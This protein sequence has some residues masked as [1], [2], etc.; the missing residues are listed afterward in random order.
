MKYHIVQFSVKYA[1]G[2][3]EY[4]KLSNALRLDYCLKSFAQS[5]DLYQFIDE[6]GLSYVYRK[7]ALYLNGG[8]DPVDIVDL[9]E[10]INEYNYPDNKTF[11]TAQRILTKKV[12]PLPEAPK[13]VAEPYLPHVAPPLVKSTVQLPTEA[14]KDLKYITSMEAYMLVLDQKLKVLLMTLQMYDKM[15]PKM[16]DVCIPE[17]EMSIK[18]YYMFY[19]RLTSFISAKSLPTE[20][21]NTF[22]NI[23]SAIKS[24]EATVNF[25]LK[26]KDIYSNKLAEMKTR[27]HWQS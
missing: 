27:K 13:K 16:L 2:I 11:L 17:W 12:N 14:I 8:L 26:D 22:S 5:D 19:Q 10:D 25:F 7:K 9:K 4:Y 6:D 3:T 23:H 24:F 15:Q 21:I 18:K 1:N 20:E